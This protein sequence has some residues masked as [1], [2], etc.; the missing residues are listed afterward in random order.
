MAPRP[1]VSREGSY[2]SYQSSS[3]SNRSSINYSESRPASTSYHSYC[4]EEAYPDMRPK[5]TTLPARDFTPSSRHPRHA[6]S[7]EPDPFEIFKRFFGTQ[8]FRQAF[9]R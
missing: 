5:S 9:M 6:A 2:N 8:D 3:Q 1:P 7:N 4:K